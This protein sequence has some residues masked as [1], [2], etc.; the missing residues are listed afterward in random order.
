MV[1]LGLGG[2]GGP[3]PELPKRENRDFSL[4]APMGGLEGR[5]SRKV[6]V[7]E[8][9]DARAKVGVCGSVMEGPEAGFEVCAG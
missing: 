4:W 7:S 3:H 2:V 9:I 1:G 6:T 5:L 8:E